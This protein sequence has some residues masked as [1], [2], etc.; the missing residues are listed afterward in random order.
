M[1]KKKIYVVSVIILSVF[2]IALL[3]AGP[4]LLPAEKDVWEFN[5]EEKAI[6]SVY[7]PVFIAV[8]L[9]LAVF[10]FL[11]IKSSSKTLPPV[12]KTRRPI[13]MTGQT[14]RAAVLTTFSFVLAIAFEMLG[15]IAVKNGI[16]SRSNLTDALFYACITVPIFLFIFNFI[17]GVV[18]KKKINGQS[19]SEK[20]RLFVSQ[21][22][23]TEEMRN[24]KL[25]SLKRLRII[26]LIYSCLLVA[27]GFVLSFLA[28]VI[29]PESWVVVVLAEGGFVILAGL[30]RFSFKTRLKTDKEE[31][32]YVSRKDY[33][34]LYSLADKAK[35]AI[36][37]DKIGI[38]IGIKIVIAPNDNVGIAQTSDA[39]YLCI[40]MILFSILSE[41]ELY[42][43][44]L[45]EFSHVRSEINNKMI[46]EREYLL[47]TGS[48]VLT[49]INL[50]YV[51]IDTL[52]EF[53]YFLYDHASSV[54]TEIEADKA[55]LK[56]GSKETVS[57]ALIKTSYYGFFRW[58]TKSYDSGSEYS[59]PEPP[60]L[61]MTNEIKKF[62]DRLAIRKNDWD[63]LADKRILALSDSHPTL[64]MRLDALGITE[65]TASFSDDSGEFGSEKQ[66]A[67]GLADRLIGVYLKETYENS[68]K[69][70]YLDCLEVVRK[71]TEEGRP[72]KAEEYSDIVTAFLQ[73]G[74][75]SEAEK[76]C[77]RAIAELPRYSSAFALFI[78]GNL[79]LGRYDDK[80]IDLLYES[81]EINNNS[82]D[83]SLDM[84]GEY[85][86]MTGNQKEL[87]IYREKA[88][89]LVQKQRDV[90]DKAGELGPKDDLRAET[91]PDGVLDRILEYIKSV[92]EGTLENVYL[93]RKTITEKDFT[94]AFIL[95]FYV[96]VLDE[97]KSEI[98]T[99]IFNYLDT[100][101]DWQYSLF[102]YEDVYQAKFEK[103]PGSCVYTGKHI[104]EE[105]KI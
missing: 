64:K 53:D 90:Y 14:L 52:Y 40:G 41:D 87:D 42:A 2:L 31:E 1:N 20:L 46:K 24:E 23:M 8:L 49:L 89:A 6:F 21:R 75:A 27:L 43:I 86:V 50:F 84:I 95:K 57:S 37:N 38:K 58:E 80:G 65:H 12:N 18:L 67:L 4:I 34:Y 10:V 76:L 92:E 47:K 33:P 98:Y 54:Y 69:E 17:M 3:I 82:I 78:K 59:D 68:R 25:L 28:G 97:K 105:N 96:D 13:R 66:K 79:L 32:G 101:D 48:S 70:K 61:P 5:S 26:T 102:L 45:H 88:V 93:V 99:K 7:L 35:K 72:L 91:L 100:S 9:L 103:I 19:E 36:Q 30:S 63:A 60:K 39:Y 71:W 73:L 11:L 55:M 74:K 56:C 51:Y 77:D 22:E 83:G 15:L 81:I 16:V 62:K 94:S 104:G 85:C 44:M 29:N